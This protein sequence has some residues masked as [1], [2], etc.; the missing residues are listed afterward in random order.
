M[1]LSHPPRPPARRR[2]PQGIRA[3]ERRS[4]RGIRYARRLGQALAAALAMLALAGC[5]TNPVTGERELQ[6]VSQQ[7]EVAVGTQQYAP[8]RQ[9]QGGD[10]AVDPQLNAYVAE[11]GGRLAAV[12]DRPLPYEFKVL[13][14][15]VPNA[16]ALPGGKIAVNRG[17]VVQ[18]ADEAELAAVLGHEIVHAAARHGAQRM[19]RGMLMQGAMLALQVG[20]ADSPY[21]GLVVGGAMLGANLVTARYSRDAELEADRY[22]MIYMQRAGYDP[23]AAISLQETFVRLSQGRGGGWLEGLFASHPPSPERVAENRRTAQELPKGGQRHQERWKARTAD[24]RRRQPA[25]DQYDRGVAALAKGDAQAAERHARE[26]LRIEPN[27]ARFHELLGDVELKRRNWRG[28]VD[29]YFRAKDRDPAYFKPYLASA[30][31]KYES[32]DRAGAEPL[33]VRAQELL[34]TST[35]AYLLGRFAEA[36]GDAQGAYELY[37]QAAAAESE[38][39]TRARRE[40]ARLGLARDPARYFQLE[41][42]LARDGEVYAAIRNRAGIA[43]TG[44]RF[45]VAVVDRAGAVV[46]GP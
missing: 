33:A 34:P 23:A 27:E 16:W 21:A 8:S 38:Y 13:N 26:A 31:A 43:V 20:A 37:S 5:G 18:L 24:L 22:G 41:P 44:V 7:Q 46:T 35:G 15:G 17:L 14:S 3:M 1:R 29:H 42:R 19:E 40:A 39:G 30:I 11:I 2:L 12:A 9:M 4:I 6:L 25:Y 32:G 45:V 36:R 10:L 28:A